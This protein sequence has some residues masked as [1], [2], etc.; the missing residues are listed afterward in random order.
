M[1]LNIALKTIA[2]NPEHDFPLASCHQNG[3][4]TVKL[5]KQVKI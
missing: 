2:L 1:K 4:E 5:Q 3:T